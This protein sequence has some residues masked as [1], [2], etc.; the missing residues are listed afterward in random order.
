MPDSKNDISIKFCIK[1]KRY[2]GRQRNIDPPFRVNPNQIFDLLDVV[3]PYGKRRSSAPR[4]NFEKISHTS[5]VLCWRWGILK[6]KTTSRSF[7][8]R[9]KVFPKIVPFLPNS[10]C[11]VG[12]PLGRRQ[13]EPERYFFFRIP[14]PQR[15]TRLA[16]EIFWKSGRGTEL[17]RFPYGPMTSKTSKLG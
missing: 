17:R 5:L 11:F 7:W 15:R 6:D 2:F 10:A 3:D 16:R 14:Q 12:K 4:T 8:R 9:P 13:K 1:K